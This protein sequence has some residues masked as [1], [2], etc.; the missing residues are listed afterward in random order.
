MGLSGHFGVH[1][2]RCHPHVYIPEAEK[3][4]VENR[5]FAFKCISG[6]IKSDIPHQSFVFSSLN[7]TFPKY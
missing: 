1:A 3:M 4:A 7:S 5:I 6:F 2:D